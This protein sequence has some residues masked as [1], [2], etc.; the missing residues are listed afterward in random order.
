MKKRQESR[1]STSLYE[2]GFGYVL[3]V[4]LAA[5]RPCKNWCIPTKQFYLRTAITKMGLDSCHK[6][7]ESLLLCY[8]VN[9]S[10]Y[11]PDRFTSASTNSGIPILPPVCWKNLRDF[12][13]TCV[14]V[15]K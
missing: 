15:C 8:N 1:K 3:A 13:V 10:F 9:S 7:H 12:V 14:N 5:W 11:S 2:G 4:E 6:I